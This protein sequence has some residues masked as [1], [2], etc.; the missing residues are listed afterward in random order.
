M[1]QFA[2]RATLNSLFL[3]A[4]QLELLSAEIG[5]ARDAL[6]IRLDLKFDFEQFSFSGVVTP[7][8]AQKILEI[9]PVQILESVVTYPET[10][11][12]TMAQAAVVS[13]ACS[14]DLIKTLY[15]GR[16]YQLGHID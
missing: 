10:V 6:I 12:I 5:F 16:K 9:L 13:I 11:N 2:P 7:G 14:L 8:T 4:L 3:F 15:I 1:F